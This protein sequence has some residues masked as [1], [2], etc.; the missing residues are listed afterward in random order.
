MT[1]NRPKISA[2]TAR[3]VLIE[4]GH[5]CAVCGDA[6]PLE[7]AHIVPWCETADHSL[8]NLICL[9]AS[10]HQRADNEKWGRKVLAEYK[11]TPWVLKRFV[12][13]EHEATVDHA[14]QSELSKFKK[15]FSTHQP[16]S[17]T[18]SSLGYGDPN[19]FVSEIAKAFCS[20]VATKYDLA[21]PVYKRFCHL[22]PV[23]SVRSLDKLTTRVKKNRMERANL[24]RD[25]GVLV[26]GG[27]YTTAGFEF[28]FHRIVM[29][30]IDIELR[31]AGGDEP[32]GF[33][34]I[35]HRSDLM[36]AATEAG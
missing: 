11:R 24:I 29:D 7:R 12:P 27:D 17:E 25:P 18:D 4:S 26:C 3:T 15:E 16:P 22:L 6:C 31:R 32:D 21:F 34:L 5:R 2:T 1:L 20:T 19:V 23:D 13:I 8:E 33:T 36:D 9:C 10:C 35:N 28:H 30:A 14:S